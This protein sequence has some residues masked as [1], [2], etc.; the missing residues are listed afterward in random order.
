MLTARIQITGLLV[1]QKPCAGAYTGAPILMLLG[2]RDD[3]LPIA[4]VQDYLAYAEAA[5]ARPPLQVTTYP[6]A[7]HAWTVSTLGAPTFYPQYRSLRKCPYLLLGAPAPAVLVEC[8][9][10]PIDPDAMQ[11]CRTQGQGYT[12]AFDEAVR[13]ASTRDAV[14]FLLRTLRAAP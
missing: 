10:R 8:R 12:M 14:A 3:N 6:G 1:S 5:G 13:A 7:Y 2:E 11:A 4:K 9:E